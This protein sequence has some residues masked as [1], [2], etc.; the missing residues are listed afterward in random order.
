MTVTE[1]AG[2]PAE[3]PDISI[4]NGTA[5]LYFAYDV[6]FAINLDEADRH[7]T[8]PKGRSQIQAKRRVSK[9]FQ[10]TPSPV[11]MSTPVDAFQITPRHTTESRVNVLL[12]EFGAVSID[13]VV[14][15]SGT[16]T[17]L[18]AFIETAYESEGLRQ[19][20]RRALDQVLKDIGPSVSRLSVS[21]HFEDYFVFQIEE[22]DPHVSVHDLIEKYPETVARLLRGERERLSH[23]ETEDII[24]NRISYG[25]EDVTFVGWDCALV[26]DT[27]PED[28]CTVL[29]YT[30]VALL[31]FAFLNN[32]L[33][34]AL[35][36]FYDHLPPAAGGKSASKFKSLAPKLRSIGQFQ[37]DTEII[38]DGVTNSLK[39]FGDVFLARLYDL[40]SRQLGLEDWQESIQRKLDTI[41]SIYGKLSDAEATRRLETLEW[42]IIVLIAVSILLP[43]IPGLSGMMH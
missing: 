26:Y 41:E 23:E 35:D 42:I 10:L 30:N 8:A 25:L 38:F 24:S 39:L 16:L 4:K 21:P 29:E 1:T 31:E 40:A 12:F 15:F 34:Q 6:G 28:I 3:R 11:W 19:H 20:A 17:E 14:P 33:N 22:F 13:L 27:E 43:F 32:K 9:Y 36:E 2:K 7:I 18:V 37:L 5:H